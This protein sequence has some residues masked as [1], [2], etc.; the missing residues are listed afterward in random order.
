MAQIRGADAHLMS[1]L[2][3]IGGLEPLLT[4][5]SDWSALNVPEVWSSH[6]FVEFVYLF[7]LESASPFTCFLRA[8]SQMDIYSCVRFGYIA[9]NKINVKD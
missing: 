4:G 8:L 5:S 1:F 2:A 6:L 7:Y 3:P 9:R